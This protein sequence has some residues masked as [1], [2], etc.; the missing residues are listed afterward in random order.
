MAPP[1][2]RSDP[3]P[4]DGANDV[5]ELRDP[6]TVEIL[7]K[8]MSARQ[9][10]A[11]A[12]VPAEDIGLI[13]VPLPLRSERQ[14]R[15]ALPYATEEFLAGPLEDTHIALGRDLTEGWALAVV[16]ARD[17]MR[18]LSEAH[19]GQALLP[20]T[21]A[22]PAPEPGSAGETVWNTLRDG[23][24]VLVRASDG[25]GF[26][27]SNG[28]LAHLWAAAGRPAILNRGA[29]LP[30]DLVWSAEPP[31]PPSPAELAIDLRQG[32]FRTRRNLRA[33]LT[34]LVAG[35]VLV[36]L[37]HLGIA[38]ADLGALRGLV[39]TQR[40]VTAGLLA[41]RIPEATV[42]DDPRLLYRSLT[43]ASAQPGGSGLL[44]RLDGASGALLAS[45]VPV[46]VRRMV[47]SADSGTL[48]LSIEAA[49]LGQLQAA[50][51]AL[52]SGGL[53]VDVGTATAGDG[54]ARAEFAL[55]GEAGQ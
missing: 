54:A 23:D 3:A 17:R 1:L 19:P 40:E 43:R 18:A 9:A 32:D 31:V 24:R 53:D 10:R 55:R 48:T 35:V 27:V 22:L 16:V 42:M 41:E 33:P 21:F 11:T 50:E 25:S 7:R 47:W 5:G 37:L 49:D 6:V 12:I 34:A 4:H 46:E 45:G 44:P 38:R 29:A 2:D 30:A 20:E 51:E 52:R 26:A 8:T 39:E 13:A 28:M 15:A 14:K 36:G